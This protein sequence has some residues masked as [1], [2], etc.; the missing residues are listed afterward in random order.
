MLNGRPLSAIL[1]EASATQPSDMLQEPEVVEGDAS[2]QA[3]APA[4]EVT[5]TANFNVP[6]TLTV[7]GYEKAQTGV[8]AGPPQIL[9][10]L[11]LDGISVSEYEA[12]QAAKAAAGKS[13]SDYTRRQ[14]RRR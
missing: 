13:V 8:T 11:T 12:K 10:A 3:P 6:N 5:A 2:E 7:S 14:L 9:P 4:E 1:A